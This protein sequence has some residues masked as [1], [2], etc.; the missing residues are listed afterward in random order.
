MNI[1]LSR[2]HGAAHCAG[3]SLVEMM[4]AMVVG[5]ALVVGISSV[6]LFSKS[7]ARRQEQI[8][9]IQQSVRI[10]FEYLASDARMAGHQ[11]C[12]T[13]RAS[14]MVNDLAKTLATNY[15]LG[16][17]GYDYATTGNAFAMTSNTPANTTTT[18]EWR[19]NT[20]ANGVATVP[21]TTL[22]GTAAG[23]GLT[24]GSDVLVIR[25]VS[26]AP[27]RLTAATTASNQLLVE[28]TTGPGKCSNGTTDKMSG[29]CVNSHALVASCTDARVFP[30]AAVDAS[31]GALTTGGTNFGASGTAGHFAPGAAEVFPLQ[32]IAYYIK[33]S[34]SG[35][36]TSLYRRVFDG[37]VAG[38]TEQELI[39]GV[40]NLQLRYGRDTTAP[41]PD[42]KIDDYVVASDVG[43]WSKVVAVR[44]ALVI[45]ADQQVGAD[46]PMAASAPVNGVSVSFPASAPQFDRR[47]FTTTVAL[48]N[49]L[50]H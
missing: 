17:E 43:D 30:V 45:R 28:N 48:R 12:Y 41:D 11:G 2:P 49:R 3:F 31:T 44:M 39:E 18:A 8:G 47:V 9:T 38:G 37:D 6:Y 26:G 32:T 42:G 5:L 20:D 36:T 46:T 24:P 27:L 16:V 14:G 35:T 23:D 7:S 13:G 4:V 22:A 50:Q 10:A 29:F 33:A 34:S 25:T 19:T 15:A 1:R 21:I 40:E